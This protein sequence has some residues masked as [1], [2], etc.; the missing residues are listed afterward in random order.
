MGKLLLYGFMVFLLAIP[1][2]ALGILW[3]L[4]DWI[5][6]NQPFHFNFLLFVSFLLGILAFL[7]FVF[8]FVLP[9]IFWP[10]KRVLRVDPLPK[11][12]AVGM[13]AYNDEDAIGDCVRDF[14]SHPSVVKVVVI[15]NNSTDRTAEVAKKSGALVVRES[16]QGYG[17]A[18][19]RAI[20]EASKYAP[21]TCLVEGDGT[22]SAR[23]L[24]KLLAYLD[25]ADMV[26]GTRNTA[27]LVTQ[28][29]QVNNWFL[30]YGNIFMAK[31]IQLRYWDRLRLTDVG[32]TFRV[33]R[34]EKVPQLL[35]RLKVGGGL[36]LYFSVR[37][38]LKALELHWK[39]I[40]VPVSL[41]ARVGESKGVGNNYW[42]GFKNG[43]DMWKE[44]LLH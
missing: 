27:E 17:A 25:N 39:L 26:L 24:D 10:P 8:E 13:T 2:F 28:D 34:S 32:C 15:D 1:V 20:A 4:A 23:D 18:C 21:I 35:P 43:L 22:F 31:L 12:V 37:M 41:K 3:W 44:I 16:I 6:Y 38:I 5:L 30:R 14:K 40:E 9:T 29:S 7:S 11:K 19:K 33:M 42:K 36:Q